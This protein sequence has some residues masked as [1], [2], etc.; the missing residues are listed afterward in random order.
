[1]FDSLQQGIMVL[2]GNSINFM[3]DLSLKLVNEVT[4]MKNFMFNKNL[5]GTFGKEDPL[6][7]KLFHLFEN[8]KSK[9]GLSGSKKNKSINGRKGTSS[10][11][12]YSLERSL[13]S[14]QDFSLREIS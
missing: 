4:K 12:K 2:E 8:S 3:N 5:D 9:D 14:K 10:E 13:N 6:D 7:M 11:S 1:M